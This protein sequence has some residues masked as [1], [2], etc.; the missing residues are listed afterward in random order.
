MI[1]WWRIAFGEADIQNVSEAIQNGNISQGPVTVEFEKQLAK[2][3]DVPYI[4]VTTSGSVA[5]MIS[6]MAV[7]IQSGDEVIIPNRTWIAT[8]HAAKMLGANAV[9]VDVQPDIPIMNVSEIRDKI[10]SKT[11]AIMPVHLGGRKVD[12]DDIREIADE[13]NLRVVED[14]AQALMV[15]QGDKYCGTLSDAGCFSFSVAKLLPTGQG[16][17][18]AT[19]SQEVYEKLMKIRSHGVSD[20]INVTYSELGFNF[21]FTDLQAAIGLNQLSFVEQ[22]VKKLKKIYQIYEIGLTKFSFLKLIPVSIFKGE[23]PLY[24]EILTQERQKLVK[25]LASHSI[26]TRPFYPSL[27]DAKY[28]QNT[29]SFPNAKTFGTQGLV[30]PCGPDQPLENIDRVLD[31]LN[32]F[33]P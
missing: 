6:L 13:F 20:V 18:V 5:L 29:G 32:Q 25:F 28:L 26:Q 24:I 17:A 21:K 10:T 15:K 19:R 16:G 14:A 22:R 4:V 30:L 7:G 8:A 31:V 12:M 33:N 9:L 1:P 3:L 2:A 27:D 23:I 11:K